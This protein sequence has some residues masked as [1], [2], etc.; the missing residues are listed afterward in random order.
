MSSCRAS[1]PLPL[2]ATVLATVFAVTATGYGAPASDGHLPSPAPVA[3]GVGW[4]ATGALFDGP[5]DQLGE[6]YCSGSVV[7]T[8]AGDIVLTAAHCVA[9]GD[10]SSPRTGMSFVPGYHDHT[11]PFGSW[12][13]VATAV[14]DTWREHADPDH[15]V[16]FLTVTR[17]G[18]P[19]IQHVVGAYHLDLDAGSP[20]SVDALGY[21]DFADVPLQRSGTT[22]RFSPTQLQLH[23]HG[24]YEGT[25]GGPWLRT[26]DTEVIAVTGGY[27]QGGRDPDTS[28]ATYLG[29]D[30]A[31]LFRQAGGTP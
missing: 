19:P 23:A 11:A 18:A 12:T 31:A 24:L 6:H 9:D 26:G 10:G 16:A 8:H 21:P 7:D 5:P 27:A 30:A 25:S 14:D 17:D 29:A 1:T 20:I 4:P 22:T 28:Y 13:V 15:D 3:P 2:L